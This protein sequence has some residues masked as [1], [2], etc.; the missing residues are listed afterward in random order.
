MLCVPKTAFSG[1]Q[2]NITLLHSEGLVNGG[3]SFMQQGHHWTGARRPSESPSRVKS[4]QMLVG[5]KTFFRIGCIGES[6]HRHRA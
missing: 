2:P 3:L 6:L 4:V 1:F 5:F